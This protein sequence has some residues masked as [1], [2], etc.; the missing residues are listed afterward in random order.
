MSTT[1]PDQPADAEPPASTTA[2]T[3]SV[4][5]S[6]PPAALGSEPPPNERSNRWMYWIIA[7]VVVVLAVVGL[8]AY[9]SAKT[10]QEAQQKAQ[11]LSQKFQKAGL[12][13]P[14][15]LDSITRSL[16][17]DGGAVC[18]NPA[19]ALGKA[20]LLDMLVNGA[21]FVGRRPVIVDRHILLG[22]LFILQVYC[23]D[24]LT[25]YQ[26]KIDQLKTADV[27]KL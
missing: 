10:N 24:K 18:D 16:G 22:E 13:V 7:L 11:Q 17:T 6:P 8:V 9:N 14:A 20:T 21:S 27:V 1:I 15:D 5:T 23:P 4:P 12:P 25:P 19:N 26:D 3:G 2:P